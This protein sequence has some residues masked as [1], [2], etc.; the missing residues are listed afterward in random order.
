[1]YS[2]RILQC[3]ESVLPAAACLGLRINPSHRTARENIILTP[4]TSDARPQGD[5][6]QHRIGVLLAILR[7]VNIAQ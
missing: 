1:M 6:D 2:T 4:Q 7:L 3:W 5:R